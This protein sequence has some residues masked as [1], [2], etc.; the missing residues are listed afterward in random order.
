MA[1]KAET[2]AL[3]QARIKHFERSLQR[4]FSLPITRSTFRQLQNA[5]LAIVDGDRDRANL[6]FEALLTGEIKE[7]VVNQADQ[8]AFRKVI[9]AFTVNAWVAKDV[10][11]K[12]EFINIIS[13]DI[14]QQ[15]NRLLYA[16]TLRRIDGEELQ[17]L[18]DFE[19]TLQ[20]LQHFVQRL[21]E[22]KDR[23][24]VSSELFQAHRKELAALK[25]SLDDVLAK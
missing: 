25:N 16:N 22:S 14:I 21:R 17:F 24:D 11:E 2:N 19:S 12:G 8:A 5:I 20:L 18:T 3:D 1:A 10:F 15:Q 7:G 4:V 13:S 23:F 6:I 9:D